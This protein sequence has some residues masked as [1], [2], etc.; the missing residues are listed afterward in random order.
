MFFMKR[1]QMQHSVG[2]FYPLK[3]QRFIDFPTLHHIGHYPAKTNQMPLLNLLK[4]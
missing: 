3:Y 2:E 4:P 1:A